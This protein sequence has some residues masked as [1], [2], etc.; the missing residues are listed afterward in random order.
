MNDRRASKPHQ[1]E[2]I[3]DSG[4]PEDSQELTSVLPRAGALPVY[5]RSSLSTERKVVCFALL[6]MLGWN[7]ESPHARQA[8][9]H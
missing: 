1:A 5:S 2:G 6:L 9:S 7:P 3:A 4:G 8:L